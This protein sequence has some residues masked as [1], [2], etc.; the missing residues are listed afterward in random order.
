M[1]WAQRATRPIPSISSTRNTYEMNDYSYGMDDYVS[2]DKFP[3]KNGATNQWRLAQDARIITL[4]EYETRKG[5]DFYSAAAGETLDQSITSTTGAADKSVN[6]TSYQAEM[7]VAAVT[8]ACNKVELNIK[9]PSSAATG[10]LLV[11][12]YED[13]GGSPGTLL[14]TTST[15]S[16]NITDSYT[17]VAYHFAKAPTVTAGQTYWIVAYVQEGGSG[18]YNW[19]STTSATTAKTSTDGITWS[20]TSYSLNFKEY[21]ATAGGVKGL[22][23][24]YKNDG[25]K[26][27]FFAHGTTLYKVT[28]GTGA[29]TAVKTG[30][31]PSAT[32]Y[33]FAFA[34][35]ILYYVN[36]YDGYRSNDGTTDTQI[37]S[38]N[39]TLICWHKGC[40]F[41]SGG[42]DPNAI[43]F[44]DFGIYDTF[45]STNFVYAGAPK[46]GD[47]PKALNSLNGYLLIRCRN[48]NFILSGDDEVTFT[49][50]QAPD[51]K[52]TY[53]Q[54]T[55]CQDEQ[56]VYFLSDDGVRRS[57]GSESK[58]MSQGVY[59]SIKNISNKDD[60]CIA[61]NRG[62]L[63]LWFTSVTGAQ[64]DSCFVWNLNFSSQENETIE[65]IDTQA[66][67]SRAFSAYDDDD[68]LIVASSVLGQLYWQEND[69]ND[70]D[71]LGS[72]LDFTVQTHYIV[73]ASPALLK[74]YRKWRPRFS[75][76]SGNYTVNCEYAYD[77]RNNWELAE[78][79]NLQGSGAIWGSGIQWGGFT[80]G[81]TAEVQPSLDI[82]GQ[83]YRTAVRYRHVGARQPVRF[84][85][86]SFVTET[87]RLR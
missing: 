53:S 87:R 76:Q 65:S 61:V 30:L 16:I 48:N 23:R 80:W 42:A 74:N 85:G 11:C 70:Y 83:H 64:N 36:G 44:S 22:I 63:Y 26:V 82:P 62:R 2:N 60:A 79:I 20:S 47:P 78:A 77:Q 13:N 40:M 86:H 8:G 27:T 73:G 18:S 68:A 29:V 41:L 55:V 31:S 10:V 56:F 72:P 75:T 19:S 54:E 5:F 51:Q 43:F 21:Y 35:D 45:T 57:N 3:V 58:L 1:P 59:E 49:I 67:V 25:S 7:F 39:Y 37:L 81:T 66:Y 12:L 71:N 52:G 33:R 17:Y 28:D 50:D 6:A 32:H 69:D 9:N 84:L 34:N 14:A 24:T 46:T 38:S 4:G 15:N